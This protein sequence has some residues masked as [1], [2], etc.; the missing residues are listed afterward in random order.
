MAMAWDG[1]AAT[2]LAA[3]EPTILA[4]VA[5]SAWS[6][7]DDTSVVASAVMVAP[8]DCVYVYG[9]LVRSVILPPPNI[10]HTRCAENE[11]TTRARFLPR[12]ARGERCVDDVVWVAF[13]RPTLL[14]FGDVLLGWRK[15]VL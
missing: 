10:L 11:D 8:A 9:Q 5:W 6:S 14:A 1:G 3:S 13:V 4:W 2:R 7:K 15:E 12:I